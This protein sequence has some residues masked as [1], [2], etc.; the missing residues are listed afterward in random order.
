MM[1]APSPTRLPKYRHFK[2]KDLAV[3]R[4]NGKDYYLGKYDSIESHEK[5]RRVLAG[6]LAGAPIESPRAADGPGA[7]LTVNE[8]ILSYIQ[9]ADTYYLKDEKPTGES[10]S[11]RY[12]LRPLRRLYGMSPACDF[13]PLALKTVRAEMIRVTLP[14]EKKGLCRNEVNRRIRHIVRCFK[15]A[16]ENELVPPSVYQG[17]RAVSGLRRGRADVRESEPVRPVPEAFVEAIR[18]HVSRQVWAMVQLQRLT[19]MRPGEVV[20]MRTI[21]VDTTGR[22]WSYTPESHKT[23]HHG[24]ERTIYLGPQA[25][26]ILR[27]WLRADLVASLFSPAEAMTERQAEKRRKRKSP[28]QPSQ[29]DRSKARP[30]KRAG[31][32]YTVDSFRRAIAYACSTAGVPEWAPNRLRHNAA[33]RL[34]K[35]FGLDVARI[36]LG[37]SSPAVTEVYAEVDRE[38][39]LDAME[40]VG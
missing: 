26:A 33:T 27:P 18:L 1:S 34:R 6:W 37:H 21:D 28:V 36:I 40:R 10:V 19:A 39:A 2:P 3:V 11:I 5:Y 24:R 23:Q 8:V 7:S 31:D 22:I 32:A 14:G 35:E 9:F 29:R 16:V 13:G 12:A 17:L 20:S 38:K 25:Q 15:W 30:K 4:I